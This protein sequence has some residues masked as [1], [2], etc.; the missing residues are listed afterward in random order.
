[1][2]RKIDDA[3]YIVIKVLFSL[4]YNFRRR[5]VIRREGDWKDEGEPF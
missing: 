3:S 1:M 2:I 4:L 5:R